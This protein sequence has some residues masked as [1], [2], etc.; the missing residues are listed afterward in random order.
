M[1]LKTYIER[2]IKL[3]KDD[4]ENVKLINKKTITATIDVIIVI[5]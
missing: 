3:S 2:S 5:N 4:F 1:Y